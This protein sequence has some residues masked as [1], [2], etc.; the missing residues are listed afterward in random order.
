MRFHR[1]RVVCF[2]LC[3]S[4]IAASTG[5]AAPSQGAARNYRDKNFDYFVAGD[6]AL[7]RAAHTDFTLALM[8][9][10][11]S[12]D[13]AFAA[14]ANHAGGGHIVI[15]RAV[16]DD[17]FDPG[18]GNYGD[19]FATRWGPVSSA[20][21]IVFHHR[22]AA[23]DPRV[24]EALRSADGIFLAGGDQSNYLRYWKGTPVQTALN[25]HVAANR[26][27]GGSSAGLAI[28]GQY[29]Y[30][31][32]DG[33]SLESKLAL[34]E[35]YNSGVTLEGDFLHFR[36]LEDIVSDTHFSQRCRLGRL[37][38]FLARIQHDHPSAAALAGIGVDERTALLVGSDGVGR[39]AAGS[40]G[41]A[42]VVTL[43]RP[44]KVL[45]EGRPLTLDDVRIVRMGQESSLDLK[46]RTVDHPAA[47]TTER[48]ERGAPAAD[49]IASK[50]M[51][52][53]VVPPDED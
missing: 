38:V 49:A 4:L 15:L 53:N 27:L 18:D 6:P 2:A 23:Y 1:H 9:G 8:G 11:G 13:A 36:W 46:S 5:H 42:W 48:I 51:L 7:P 29:S 14:I 16:S 35:P 45:K 33:G 52:R 39:L 22:E 19:S 32:S 10:G 21:T 34:N 28:L 25:A 3:A 31:A 20:Q 24:L 26:P 30:T 41:G 47:A 17:G 44:P 12:V 40:T 50:I 37:I 43:L